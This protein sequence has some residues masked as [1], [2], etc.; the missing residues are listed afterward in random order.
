MRICLVGSASIDGIPKNGVEESTWVLAHALLEEGVEVNLIAPTP[1]GAGKAHGTWGEVPATWV[2]FQERL[3]LPTAF[4][5]LRRAALSA[6]EH[7]RPDIAQGQGILGCGNAVADWSSTRSVIAAHGNPLMDHRYHYGR[8]GY[9]PRTMLLRSVASRSVLGARV[10]VNVTRSWTVNMPVEPRDLRHIPNPVASAF[11]DDPPGQPASMVLYLGGGRSIKGL[12]LLLDAWPEVTARHPDAR[13]HA[14]GLAD[15]EAREYGELPAGC[16]LHGHIDTNAVVRLMRDSLAVVVPSRYEVAP[17]V[18]AEAM[19][20]GVPVVA[21]AVGGTPELAAGNA[22][23]V[24]PEAR[25]IAAG[26]MQVLDD[27]VGAARVASA[28]RLAAEAFRPK[29][30]AQA[31]IAVYEDILAHACH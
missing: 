13:L 16:E 3:S 22:I 26:L 31:H 8:F 14:Y 20:S 5:S 25:S 15:A 21:T 9:L 19:A 2:G 12:D 29:T 4:S 24:E 11:F 1:G 7:A 6:L 17:I 23:L 10:V 18:V 28:S 27:P 30:V